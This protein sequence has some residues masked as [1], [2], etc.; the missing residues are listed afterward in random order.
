V[1]DYFGIADSDDAALRRE[2]MRDAL[3]ALDAALTDTLPYLFGLLGIVEGA[4]PLAEMDPQIK[5]QRTLGAIQ[6]IVLRESL[7]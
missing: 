3:N 2:K 5:R 6:R 4:D 1:R 7:Q